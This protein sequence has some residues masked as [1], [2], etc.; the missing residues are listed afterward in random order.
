[1]TKGLA[2]VVDGLAE[3]CLGLAAVRQAQ[4]DQQ[5]PRAVIV[6]GA[7]LDLLNG[8]P[9]LDPQRVL[10]EIGIVELQ[11]QLAPVV[12]EHVLGPLSLVE[13]SVHFD[14]SGELMPRLVGPSG[15]ADLKHLVAICG[16]IE[17]R[18]EG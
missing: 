1:M 12:V 6:L 13:L 16:Q 15:Y 11:Q 17:R 18:H 7:G 9:S 2:V 4:A 5:P 3:P 8:R 10:V 14:L